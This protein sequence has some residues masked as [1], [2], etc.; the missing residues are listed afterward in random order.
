M[1]LSYLQKTPD[2]TIVTIVN[3]VNIFCKWDYSKDQHN[4]K[5]KNIRNEMKII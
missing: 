3:R 5:F 2:T 4:R 1:L